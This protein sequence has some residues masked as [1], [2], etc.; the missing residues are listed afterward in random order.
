M[1]ND[2]GGRRGIGLRDWFAESSRRLQRHVPRTVASLRPTKVASGFTLGVLLQRRGSRA[3]D[4]VSPKGATLPYQP[5]LILR[6]GLAPKSS[7]APLLTVQSPI[8][9]AR[10]EEP[11]PAPTQ[12]PPPPPAGFESE[13]RGPAGAA[14]ELP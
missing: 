2:P 11:T 6:R 14:A 9:P 1:A 10:P 12:A 4:R 5:P 13:P 8:P 7:A 3:I